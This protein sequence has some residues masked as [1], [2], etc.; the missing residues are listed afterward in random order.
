M[1]WG[2]PGAQADSGRRLA[3][4]AAGLHLLL[5]PLLLFPSA[6]ALPGAA[7]LAWRERRAA[8]VRFLLAWAVPAWLVF[9]AAPTKLPHY[10][11][12]LYPA[13]C[14]LMARA[15]L[16]RGT[17]LPRT[18]AWLGGVGAVLLAVAGVAGPVLLHL[19][20]WLGTPAVVAAGVVGCVAVQGRVPRAAVTAVMLAPLLY[21]AILQWE[22]PRLWPLWLSPRVVAA[23]PPGRPVGAVGFAEPSLMVLA[24]TGTTW[25]RADEG[26]AALRNGTVASLV[27][28]D[29]DLPAVLA[30]LDGT[31]PGGAAAFSRVAVP[32]YNYSRGRPVVL[33]ILAPRK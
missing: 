20:A 30:G 12:P 25:L 26:V 3:L 27:V 21:G 4:G 24:G 32:G 13:L 11:L 15:V 22:L 1:R 5:L 23:L 9:E 7:A 16:V 19:P 10:T 28:G 14:L 33:T 17:A 31:V 6:A 18:S 8:P 29:R 2:R